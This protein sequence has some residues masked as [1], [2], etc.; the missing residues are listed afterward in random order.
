MKDLVIGVD[1][2][3][4]AC[5]AIAWDKAGN[6]VA[7]GRAQFEL[8]SPNPNWY[9]QNANDWW[10][11]LCK[12]LQA[13]V[14]QVGETRIAAVCIT[15]QRETFA[16]VDENC[17][18]I[19][20]AL[21][22]VDGRAKSEVAWLDETFGN[23]YLH[24]LTG[25]GPAFVQS[26][27]KLVWLKAHEPQLIE[28]A[29]KFVDV[30]AFLVYHLTGNWITSLPCADPMGLVDMRN[31]TWSSEIIEK[32]GLRH[33]QFVDLA[34]PGTTIGEITEA[35]AQATSLLVGTPVIAG[36][37]D[38]QSAG[39]GTNITTAGKAYLNLG[40]AM[41]SGAHAENYV[42]DKAFR[43]LCSPL[44]GAFVAEEV[45]GGGTFT[46]SWFV[47]NFAP[48][49][50]MSNFPLS[51]EEILEVA[52]SKVPPGSLGLMSVPYWNAVMPPF[53]DP[54]ATGMTVGWTG[55][56]RREHFYRS[57]LEGIAFEHRQAM[58]Q[59][60]SATNQTFDEFIVLGGGSKSDLWCQIVADISGVEVKRASTAEA[61]NLGAGILA[62]VAAGWYADAR[63]A[64][65]SMTS[66]K[67]IF[68][69]DDKTA[70][71]YDRLFNEVYLHLFPAVQQSIKRLTELTYS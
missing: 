7:E 56:H 64:A 33:D 57:I 17:R 28:R 69:P 16:I 40:T 50:N 61:T 34:M 42:A 68:K 44:A 4:T 21:T 1:S 39:L 67:D 25:K 71:I 3:T 60:A 35:A 26:L 55:A 52:A 62:T 11:A 5:K 12:S 48:D 38:G 13:V 41:V 53:W 46:V 37:G 51:I 45:L 59:I 70:A 8:L 2:S 15:H 6:L 63:E 49:A 58:E 27:P 14:S 36:A 22:W 30:H 29:Y 47:Q 54:S 31:G 23:D 20:N 19:H 66:T 9:E 18:P 32:I 10:Q 24:D 65:N 43:T